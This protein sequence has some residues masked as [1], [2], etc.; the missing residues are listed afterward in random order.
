MPVSY[1]N[2]RG[3]T[4]YLHRGK[5]KAGKPMHYFSLKPEGLV[6]D[7]MPAGLEIYEHPSGQVFLRRPPPRRITDKEIAVVEEEIARFPHL[8]CHLVD[9]RKDTITVYVPDQDMAELQQFYGRWGVRDSE[10]I[11]RAIDRTVSYSPMMQFILVDPEKRIFEAKRYCFLGSI[12]DWVHIGGPDT[13]S[14][15]AEQYIKH[16]GRES[17]YNLYRSTIDT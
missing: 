2:R 3:Q 10:S 5:D 15:L 13:L 4:Y 12:D 9:V 16:L 14:H 11:Q 6:A 8:R 17:Y 7:T 1:V